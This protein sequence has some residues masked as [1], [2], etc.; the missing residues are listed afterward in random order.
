MLQGITDVLTSIGEF[1]SSIVDF[2]GGLINDLVNFVT[3]LV[4]VGSDI[5]NFLSGIP[6]YVTTG[7]LSL[8]A[9]MIVLRVVGRD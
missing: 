2:I 3:S 6:V 4:T 1:F 7:I 5:G 8:V 9:L